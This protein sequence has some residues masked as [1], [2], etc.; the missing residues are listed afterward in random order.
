MSDLDSQQ[1]QQGAASTNSPLALVAFV[2]T[3]ISTITI[4]WLLVP[5]AWMIPMTVMTWGI[6]KGKR[7]VTTGFAICSLLFAI[8][9]LVYCCLSSNR[10]PSKNLTA[11]IKRQ[12]ANFSKSKARTKRLNNTSRVLLC[13]LSAVQ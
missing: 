7:E 11:I 2:L 13:Y 3:L 6:Y 10:M 12:V 5:L 4:G 1:E 8:L 9:L